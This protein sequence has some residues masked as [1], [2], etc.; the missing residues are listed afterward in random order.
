MATDENARRTCETRR[1]TLWTD[2]PP[3]ELSITCRSNTYPKGFYCT[4]TLLHRTFI[5]TTFEFDVQHNQRSLEVQPDP[6]HKNRCHVRFPEVFSSHPYFV[7]ITA[8]NAL[9]KAATTYSFEES[10]IVKP[11]PPVRVVATPVKDNPRRLEVSWN[12]P[13]TWPD[14]NSFPLK[15]F[16]RYRP[17]IREQWQHPVNMLYFFQF[18]YKQEGERERVRRE[19]EGKGERGRGVEK[20][21]EGDKERKEGE[22]E[23]EVK[24]RKKRKGETEKDERK[25]EVGEKI[26]KRREREKEERETE[27]R[28]QRNKKGKE[29]ERSLEEKELKEK[30]EEKRKRE[31]KGEKKERWKMKEKEREKEERR[32]RQEERRSENGLKEREWREKL[33][34]KREKGERKKKG[35]ERRKEKKR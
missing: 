6:S 16:L 13:S 20:R 10:Y 29:R 26:R 23:E 4:W 27:K 9:G 2:V 35:R 33:M 15:Y 17:L 19:E 7:N 8:I 25:K 12:S 18:Y 24:E 22:R 14:T 5:P 30:K 28:K 32:K 3:G 34:K 11:D 31:E 21:G 1:A